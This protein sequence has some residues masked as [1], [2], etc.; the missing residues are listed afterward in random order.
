VA[1]VVPAAVAVA[2]PLEL[3]LRVQQDKETV[4]LL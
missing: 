1:L 3:E 2:Q 4:D